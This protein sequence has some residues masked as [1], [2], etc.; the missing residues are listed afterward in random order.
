[1]RAIFFPIFLIIFCLELSA[2]S[3]RFRCIIRDEPSTSICIGWDQTSGSMP[4]LYFSSDDYDTNIKLYQQSIAPQRTIQSK[5]MNNHFVRLS[6]LKPNTVYYFV[7]SDSEGNSK[8]YSFR[9]LP[10]DAESR[11][12]IISGGDSRKLRAARVNANK[13]VAKLHPHFV[14]FNGDMSS[15]DSDQ[16]WKEWLDDWT[17]TIGADGR[18]T[19]LIPNR[20]NSEMSNNSIHELF[21]VKNLE[22]YSAITFARGLLRIY[23]LNSNIPANGIQRDWLERDLSQHQQ[24]AWRLA[25]YHSS[26]R[27]NL[28]KQPDNIDLRKNWGTLFDKFR[29]QLAFEADTCFAK[30]SFPLKTSNDRGNIDGFRVDEL[31]GTVYLGGGGWGSSVSEGTENNKLLIASGSFNHFHWIFLELGKVEIRTVKTDNAANASQL[32]DQNRFNVPSGIEL[33]EPGDLKLLTVV[34]R[35][36][37]SFRALPKQI[38]TEIRQPKAHLIA[39]GSIELTWQTVYEEKGM[40]YRIQYSSNR[41]YWKTLAEAEG[42]GA[43]S[44]KAND[45]IFSDAPGFKKGK[46]FYRI[47]ALDANGNEKVEAEIDARLLSSDGDMETIVVNQNIGILKTEIELQQVE[48]TLLEILNTDRKVVFVQKMPLKTGKQEIIL[49]IKHLKPGHYLFEI[50]QGAQTVRKNLM[51]VGRN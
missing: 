30:F 11:L 51:V 10:D 8:R 14:L 37:D 48:N 32:D 19:A 13:L 41:V 17:E 23:T 31:N 7:V 16:E 33:W 34:N 3:E 35:Q 21:D 49:N 43:N 28:K 4:R 44:T 15:G 38:L 25:Q 22:I 24:I 42:I 40:H 29:V 6:N 46:I 18:I 27:H 26:M 47:I 1:M 50:N 5:G 9:T 12:S 2:K 36:K 45:Y 39:D 20:G